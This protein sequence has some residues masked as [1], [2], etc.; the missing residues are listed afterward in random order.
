MMKYW[1]T[2]YAD[3]M[4]SE[5]VIREV[6][7]EWF[8]QQLT[9]AVLGAKGLEGSREWDDDD[10]DRCLSEEALTLAVMPRYHVYVAAKRT[11]GARIG[12]LKAG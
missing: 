6:V 8:E 1:A 12:S 10:L 11:L 4:V 3:S 7:C 2:E 5:E 9:E